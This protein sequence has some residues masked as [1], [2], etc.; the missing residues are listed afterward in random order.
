MGWFGFLIAVRLLQVI[1]V[2]HTG[3]YFYFPR[4]FLIL[5]KLIIFIDSLIVAM[6][7]VNDSKIGVRPRPSIHQ[8]LRFLCILHVSI[9]SLSRGTG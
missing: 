2:R 3:L 6:S 5:M 9:Y 7:N 1:S 4:A 8:H